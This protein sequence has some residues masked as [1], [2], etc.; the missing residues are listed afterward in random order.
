MQ[1]RRNFLKST[2]ATLASAWLPEKIVAIP[3][4]N[5]AAL[6][7][8]EA[9]G[10]EIH[11]ID[12]GRGNATFILGP[13]GTSLL[14]DAG[15]AHS[16]ERTMSPARPDKSRRAGEWIARY[17]RR[18]LARTSRNSLDVLLLTHLHGDHVGEVTEGSP[19]SSLGNYRL[20]G[21]ADVAEAIHVNE[22]LDRG[23]PDYA[24]PTPPKDPTSLNY[25]ALARSMAKRGTT[26]Q[27]ASAGSLDQLALRHDVA[28][29]P[30]F[31]ARILSVNGELWTGSGEG[32]KAMFPSPGELADTLLPS[33]NM[34]SV[35]LRIQYGA[36]RYYS[37]GDL[38]C[39]TEYG[40]LPW[41]DI[42]SPVANSAGP[43]SVAVANHHGYFDACGPAMVRA[44]RPRVWVLPTWHVSHPAMNVMANIF[45]T[46]LYPGDRS[47]FAVGMTPEALL[48]TER[49]SSSL[50]SSDGHV[51]IRVPPSG[52]EFTVHV[53]DARDELGAAVKSFGPFAT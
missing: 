44:L 8:P 13:D 38:T 6:P 33:E 52:N 27:R 42:E 35:S 46:E 17:V 50:S 47:V 26:V 2:A 45:S 28:R 31:S 39:E 51:V 5:A 14:I 40:R 30:N 12:T 48:T 7:E 9:G 36:F 29:Y 22:I 3:T 23:W 49:F 4:P 24:Y 10:L 32:A 11:H 16:L 21:A 25:I 1:G 34:C 15:E 41:R 37:G 43:V 18:Q 53:V 19:L 20:T